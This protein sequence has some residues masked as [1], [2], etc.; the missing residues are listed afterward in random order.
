MLTIMKMDLFWIKDKL[1]ENQKEIYNKIAGM[2]ALTDSTFKSLRKICTELNPP[3]LDELGLD[4]TIL[5]MK[6][7]FERTTCTRCNVSLKT[8]GDFLQREHATT[9]F[10]ILQETLTNIAKHASASVVNISLEQNG[11]DLVLKVSDN[12]KGITP[13]QLSCNKTFGLA[14]MMERARFLGGNITISGSRGRGTTVIATI[15][16][17]KVERC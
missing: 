1:H 13:E 12:G 15:P 2:M 7:E 16:H 8:R 4:A 6:G 3:I 9:V 10:R 14:G 17:N 5:W 11:E